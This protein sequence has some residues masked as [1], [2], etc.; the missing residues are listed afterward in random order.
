MVEPMSVDPVKDRGNSSPGLQLRGR[1]NVK[2]NIL[3]AG[4]ALVFRLVALGRRFKKASRKA[5]RGELGSDPMD[6]DAERV[7]EEE[8]KTCFRFPGLC[9]DSATC[10][11]RVGE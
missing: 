4:A 7:V 1:S 5:E 6:V 10:S 2:G 11:P 3:S 9:E 8:R